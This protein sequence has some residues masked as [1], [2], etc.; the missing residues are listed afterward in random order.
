MEFVGTAWEVTAL[1]F[2]ADNPNGFLMKFRER[3]AF[4][5]DCETAQRVCGYD[6]A[7]QKS[8]IHLKLQREKERNLQS[9]S[10]RN[11]KNVCLKLQSQTK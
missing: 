11:R 6:G 8:S 2:L 4:D 7:D 9:R 10:N 3:K 1:G 5:L